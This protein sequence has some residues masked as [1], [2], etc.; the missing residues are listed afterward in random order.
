MRTRSSLLGSAAV[1]GAGVAFAFAAC[2][3]TSA[4]PTTDT[5]SPSFAKGGQP[6]SVKSIS[7]SPSTTNYLCG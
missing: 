6:K 5:V 2:S 4:P 1:M 7:V 3:D